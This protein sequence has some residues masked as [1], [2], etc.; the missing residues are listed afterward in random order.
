MIGFGCT[1]APSYAP[2]SR[3]RHSSGYHHGLD[4]AMPCGTALFAGLVG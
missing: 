1:R 4:I 2:D 3:C